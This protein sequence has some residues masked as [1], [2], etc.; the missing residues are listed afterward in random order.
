MKKWKLIF[1]CITLANAIYAQKRVINLNKAERNSFVIETNS[2]NIDIL[3]VNA[4]L[5]YL[6]SNQNSTKSGNYITIESEGLV[7]TFNL[8]KPNIP[9]YSKL[10]E[11][12][13]EASVKFKTISYDEEII[14][15][16]AKGI[17]YKIIPAQPSISKSETSNKFYYDEKTYTSNM[18]FNTKIVDF[19]DI[20]ILRSVRL[21]RIIINPIQYNPVQNK[22]KILNNLKI[23]VEFVGSNHAKTKKL[24]SRYS[25]SLFN[26]IINDYI[27]NSPLETRQQI[28]E[29]I[30]Y[31]I[32][33]DRMFESTLAPFISHKKKLGYNVIIAYTDNP[34]VGKST[35]SIKTY[36]KGLYNNPPNN[37]NPPHYVLLVGDIEQIPSYVKKNHV[38]DLYYFDYT[39]DNIP[40]V[41]YGRFSARNPSQLSPQIEK[42]IEYENYSMPDPRYLFNAVL[43]AG[44]DSYYELT[45]GNGQVNYC[46]KEYFNSDNGITAYTYLQDEPAN[47]N[48]SANIISN[49]NTGVGF[50]NYS[51]HCSPN[52]WSDPNFSKGNISNLT[53]THKYGLWVGNC[54]QSNRFSEP[55]CFGEAALRA[56]NKGAVG[57]IGATN[58]SYWDEDYWWAVGFKS[59][60]TNPNYNSSHLGAFDRLFHTHGESSNNWYSTQGQLVV[61]GNLAVQESNS[62]YKLYYWEIYHLLGDPALNIRFIPSANCPENI[63]ITN[64]ITS[65]SHEYLASNSI[66]ASYK[67]SNNANVHYGANNSII[68]SP[69]FSVK[70]G[71]TFRADLNG[72]SNNKQKHIT[73]KSVNP[74]YS[75]EKRLID[76]TSQIKSSIESLDEMF[77]KIYPN[78][79]SNN[80]F[81]VEVSNNYKPQSIIVFNLLGTVLYQNNNIDNTIIIS[82]INTKGII[83]IKI[84]FEDKY[85]IK[86]ILLK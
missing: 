68:L 67:I 6:T 46:K 9:I 65:G 25:N 31:V 63:T 32:V 84:N 43:V 34:N 42:T 50:A 39:N 28:T 85:I 18:Y 47:G 4:N 66:K 19:E 64:N 24:K 82:N 5:S 35:T 15:L 69:N 71:S 21:G 27:Q 11:L 57:Y 41:Y 13:L 37:Y 30:T 12:P 23:E 2:K 33:A 14:D 16:T 81:T 36:L 10:I 26:N 7:K 61:G 8:G 56:A 73:K 75:D 76:T 83:Y 80:Q 48:Y 22:L 79:A 40:D 70:L 54:C 77:V 62:M 86:K 60:S 20:G 38:T 3:N 29:T 74:N 51:A 55:E 72:C 59:V 44:N 78:P 49:I 52:G 53:N 45:H 58:N 17:N 1:L